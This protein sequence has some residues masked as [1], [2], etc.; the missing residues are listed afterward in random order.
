MNQSNINYLQK[1]TDTLSFRDLATTTIATYASYL[2][3]CME[4]YG[5]EFPGKDFL[6]ITYEQIRSY[7]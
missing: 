7:V 6:G 3:E 2:T 1:H 5:A 4:W